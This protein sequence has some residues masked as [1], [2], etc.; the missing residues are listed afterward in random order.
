MKRKYWALGAV[1]LTLAMLFGACSAAAANGK[2]GYAL[3]EAKASPGYYNQVSAEDSSKGGASE[4]PYDFEL[5]TDE[6]A[7]IVWT[8]SVSMETTEWEATVADLKALF[9]A[10]NVQIMTSNETGG[11]SYLSNG[12][13]RKSARSAS[14]TL[15]VPSE[16]FGAFMDGFSSIKGSVTGSSK[17]R[18]DL[19]KQYNENELELE[20]LET[21]YEDL[22]RLLEQAKDLSEIMMIRD[23]MTQVMKE[24]KS[25]SQTNN[26]IDYD[27][28]YS[29]VTLNLREVVVYS[30]PEKSENWFVRFGK[31]FVEGTS[32]FFE[33]LGDVVVW[34]GGH[35]FYLILIAALIGLPIILIVRGSRKRRA[36]RAAAAEAAKQKQLEAQIRAQ[37]QAAAAQTSEGAARE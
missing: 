15:R 6:S 29:R 35:I 19:T 37:A 8:G 13:P 1:L 34:L 14:F 33:F 36:K 17:N 32:D 9:A 7:K 5:A 2:S 18:A 24:I 26:T 23:R 20:L 16:N 25:L 27:V 12:T 3:E 30:D 31:S 21:E 10:Y 4:V 28:L 22:K 11:T